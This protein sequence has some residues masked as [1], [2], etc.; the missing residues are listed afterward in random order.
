[1]KRRGFLA[2]LGLSPVAAM[3]PAEVEAVDDVMDGHM[4]SDITSPGYFQ[5]Y[6]GYETL[7]IGRAH[8]LSQNIARNNALTARLKKAKV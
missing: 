4:V 8:T 6:S 2:L 5:W 7:N 3:L 1:M